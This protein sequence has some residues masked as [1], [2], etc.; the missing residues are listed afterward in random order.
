MSTQ[1]FS[2]WISTEKSSG[3]QVQAADD[4][5]Q[6]S[7]STREFVEFEGD[8]WSEDDCMLIEEDEMEQMT[9]DEL[10]FNLSYG[11]TRSVTYPVDGSESADQI[12]DVD[13]VQYIDRVQDTS[14]INEDSQDQDD[15][16]RLSKTSEMAD[17]FVMADQLLKHMGN[18]LQDFLDACDRLSP[19]ENNNRE[20]AVEQAAKQD[21]PQKPICIQID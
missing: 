12:Q 11:V 2:K 21:E 8:K 16:M 18:C 1:P 5:S 19:I 3:E 7:S 14:Q 13:R 10:N 4:Q 17:M 15:E 6:V 9:E 20:Q